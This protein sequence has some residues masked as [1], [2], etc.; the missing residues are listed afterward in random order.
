MMVQVASKIKAQQARPINLPRVLTSFIGRKREIEEVKQL[1]SVSRLVTMTGAAGCGKTRLALRLAPE[2][3]TQYPDGVYWIELAPLG[4]GSLIT[5]TITK[6]LNISQIPDISSQ[7]RLL[8]AL[9]TKQLLLLIDNCE[10]LLDEC[11]LL[12]ERLLAATQV[13]ILATSR[14]PLRV[15]G[16][17]LYPVAP[18][19]LPPSSI[20]VDDADDLSQFEA[21]QL[22]VERA[23]S[24]LPAFALK[25]DNAL[26]IATLC[27]R[28]DGIPLAIELASARLNVLTIQQISSRLDNLFRL[29]PASSKF[30][31]SHHET[32]QAAIEWSYDLLSEQEQVFLMRMSVFTGGCSLP[33]AE[34]VCTGKGIEREQVLE[35]LS[36]LVNKSL[37]SAETLQQVE[38]R[39][40]CLET[41][42]QYAQHKLLAS[43]E[44]SLIH[45]RHLTSF[46]QLCEASEPKIRGHHQQL[47][48]NWLEKEYDNIRAA[49]SWSLESDQIEVGLCIA[50]ALY[51]FW[52][53][54]DY[55]EE[56]LVWMERLL[57]QKDANVSQ[58]VHANALANAAFM[59]GFRGN[60]PAQIEYGRRAALVAEKAGEKGKLALAWAL[61]A[62]AYSARAA[63]DYQTEFAIAERIIQLRRELNDSYYLGLSLSIYSFTAM[64]LGKFEVARA[65]LDEALPLLHMEGNPYRIAMALNFSGDLARCERDYS[66]AL[67]NYEESINLLSDLDAV[68]DLASSLHNLGHTY[69]HL[70]DVERA[71]ALFDES[72][73]IHQ[74]Q[75]NIPGIA[76]CLIGFAAL[77]ITKDLPAEGARLLAASVAIGGHRITSMWAA[78][79]MEYDH[80]LVR[81]QS[82]LSKIKFQKEQV[83]GQILSIERAISYAQEV[84][85]KV[86]TMQMAQKRLGMLTDRERQVAALIVQGR[87]NGEIADEL[88]ISKRTVESHVGNIL[89]KISATNRTQ[90]LRWGIETGLEK[91]NN[92]V[93]S[94]E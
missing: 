36:S 15:I 21:I 71:H 74:T 56:G 92:A 28:L 13:N 82:A 79:R 35:L 85:L 72:L 37:I 51:Q 40:Y 68:R 3:N 34:A 29:F 61:S 50:I 22:F 86:S 62:L 84:A 57:G 27:R 44:W 66:L 58:V 94:G 46:L 48:L 54:R 91:A 49:L 41:I 20:S 12:A 59:A 77:A 26:I 55:V 2:L 19:T 93:R 63:G 42:R 24:I 76:E 14:E 6:V 67:T 9:Q 18:L 4:D 80:Y 32:L 53:I 89:S 81:A 1:L 88:V 78:T 39:Y 38:A 43:G 47:W 7:E 31:I 65:M 52:T 64:S 90:I 69:L 5:Q 75:Q 33:T 83:K 17:R 87:S 70:G 60:T 25:P 8:D 45:D 11:K 16:E 30:N 10:H 73:A 23:R